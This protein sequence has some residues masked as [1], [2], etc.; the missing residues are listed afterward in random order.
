L[1]PGI[2]KPDE[3][4]N[5]TSTLLSVEARDSSMLITAVR[6]HDLTGSA[7]LSQIAVAFQVPV[8]PMPG[9]DLVDLPAVAAGGR[10][11]PGIG[12]TVADGQREGRGARLLQQ[13]LRQVRVGFGAAGG[14]KPELYHADAR[15][16]PG[17]TGA[18]E[19]LHVGLPV[20]VRGVAMP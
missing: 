4:S 5:L 10:T 16:V 15:S 12:P 6:G 8:A 9:G 20:G 1:D 11:G 7:P 13:V 18:A 3:E 19:A 14:P 17:R 2:P